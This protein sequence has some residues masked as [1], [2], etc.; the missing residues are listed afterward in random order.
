MLGFALCLFLLYSLVPTFLELA[1]ATPLNL[2]LL[3][4]D[5][6]GLLI[7]IFIFGFEVN[8]LYALAFV[9]VIG[10]VVIFETFP[11]APNP[12]EHQL[13]LN[14]DE[15]EGGNANDAFNG[16]LSAEDN[17]VHNSDIKSSGSSTS[18]GVQIADI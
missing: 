2:S 8:F 13:L 18:S 1:G 10:G 4:S 17:E 3:T 11:Y 15:E 6:Y 7:G 12:N 9:V 16:M 5:F 14:S